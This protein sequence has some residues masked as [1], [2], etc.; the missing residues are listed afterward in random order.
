[1][2]R[3]MQM[4]AMDHLG[5]KTAADHDEEDAVVGP[6]GVALHHGTVN[7]GPAALLRS[8]AQT[9]VPGQQVLVAGG[10]TVSGNPG[11]RAIDQFGRSAI[12]THGDQGPQA[13]CRE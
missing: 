4:Q 2:A 12:A 13:P 7:H 9:E 10:K 11:T 3:A 6:A 5:V 8:G 1:M